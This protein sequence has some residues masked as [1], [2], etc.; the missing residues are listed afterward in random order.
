MKNAARVYFL[1]L[2]II[3]LATAGSIPAQAEVASVGILPVQDESGTQVPPEL[4]LKVGQDFKQKLTLSYQDILA[5]SISGLSESPSPSVE[6]LAAVGKQQG[7]QYVL[8]SGVLGLLSNKKGRELKCDIGL[9]AEL[10]TSESGAIT[11]LRANGTGLEVNP[12]IDDAR[13]WDAY[14]FK[15]KSFA[16]SALGQALSMAIDQLVQQV[17]QVLSS[18][19]QQV[20]ETV[21][22]EVQPQP[23]VTEQAAIAYETDQELQQLIAQADSLVASGVASGTDI[24][25]LQQALEGLRASLDTKVS[26]MT[27]GQDTS[28]VDQE[29]TRIRTE[30]QDIIAAST[31]EAISQPPEGEPQAPGGEMQT[32][33]AKINE[34]LGEALNSILKIQEICTAVQNF[35]QDQSSSVPAEMG[36]DYLPTEEPTSD[37]SGVVVDETGYPV[38]GATVTDPQSGASAVTDSSG[39][40]IIP[41]IP[42]GRFA[43]MKV[44]KAGKQLSSGKIQLQPGRMAFADWQTGT[45]GTGMKAPGIKILPASVIIASK[46]GVQ[47]AKSGTIKGVVR[48]EQGKPVTRALVMVKGLGMART[49][50]QGR[51]MFVNVPQGGYQ[52]MV[53]KGG[54]T[55]QTERV[56]VAAKKVVESKTLYKGKAIKVPA[57]GKQVVLVRGAG[58][59]LVGKVSN[60]YRQPLSGAKVTA[61]YTGGAMSVFTDAKG[62]Y[63]F[64]NVKQGAYRLLANRAG[65]QEA[66]GNV[67]LEGT[68]REVRDFMLEK[69]SAEIQKVLSIK[70]STRSRSTKAATRFMSD[71]AS[72]TAKGHL[73]GVVRDARSGKPIDDATVKVYGHRTVRTDRQGAYRISDVPPGTCRVVVS[74]RDYQQED[75]TV[76][77]RSNYTSKEYFSLKGKDRQDLKTTTSPLLLKTFASSGQVRGKVTDSKTGKPVVQATVILA[78]Q[79]T[80][81]GSSGDFNF[82]NI[83]A[84]SYTITIEKTNYQDS[85]RRITVKAGKTTNADFRLVYKFGFQLKKRSVPSVSPLR[86]DSK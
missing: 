16:Q 65:Y 27:E 66:S 19:S 22:T 18:S 28:T 41:S 38:E 25:S 62:N 69:S 57:L 12:T 14:D 61:V 59:T 85:N 33:I 46:S 42:S 54:A 1:V 21:S 34:L 5:R 64:R 50:S 44:F 6:Q 70:P 37:V 3:W 80:Q 77:I 29:I 10:I 63:E 48:D 11:S 24:S 81:S 68:Q 53:Q 76:T 67:A 32:G 36:E 31:Q 73:S 84:G 74:H 60:K 7:I 82:Q 20:T 45:G 55:V 56:R 8:R 72:I 75:K 43:T 13:S 78:N 86:I 35:S 58:A 79:K 83:P 15:G 49:D 40:Y 51:Y 30:L 26:L 4:L 17:H 47:K 52:L 71:R 9:Y 39:S 2:C 23:L